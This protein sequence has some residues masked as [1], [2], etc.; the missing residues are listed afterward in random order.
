MELLR[1]GDK[2]VSRA[3]IDRWVSRILTLRR[4]G[5]SQQEV[6]NALKIDRTF[7]S[8]LESLGEIRKGRGVAVLG[9]PIANGQDL[10]VICREYGVDWWFLLNEQERLAFVA[11]NGLDLF[12]EIMNILS[13]IRGY[14]AVVAIGSNRRVQLIEGLLDRDVISIILGESPLTKDVRVDP[15]RFESVIKSL[16]CQEVL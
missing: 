6:A 7:I 10:E 11:K 15:N 14:D 8:R 2:V 3:Q 13:R 5:Y 16:C 12:N 9:F 4:Q 1:I